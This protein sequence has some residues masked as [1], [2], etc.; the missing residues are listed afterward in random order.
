MTP[1]NPW[2]PQTQRLSNA[3]PSS[4]SWGK[5]GDNSVMRPQTSNQP[6]GSGKPGSV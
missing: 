3:T 6:D 2:T 1:D 5:P 4:P